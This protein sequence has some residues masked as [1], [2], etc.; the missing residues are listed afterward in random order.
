MNKAKLEYIWIGGNNELRSKTKVMELPLDFDIYNGL[1]KDNINILP[2]WNFDGS[3]TNQAEGND[4][5]VLLKPVNVFKNPFN[6]NR[7]IPG[8]L[9]LCETFIHDTNTPH[10]TNTRYIARKIFTKQNIN[11]YK[12]LFGIEREFFVYD[13]TKNPQCPI[14]WENGTPEAQGPYYCSVGSNVCFGKDFLEDVL[15]LSLDAN[16]SITGSNMEVCPGQMEIQICDQGIEASDQCVILS[17]ILARLG[18]DYGYSIDWRAKPIEGDW[19]GSGCHVNFSTIQ[20]R[21]P[22][23]SSPFETPNGY[24]EILKSIERLREKHHEHIEVYGDDNDSRLTG[25]H[26][27]SSM[28]TFSYGVADRGASIRIPRD[29]DKNGYGY[30]EDRR[31]SS[32]AD[33]YIV[34]SKIFETSIGL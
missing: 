12:P 16:L 30:F 32:S 13:T 6:K 22:L 18:E 3:S 26:E 11:K 21:T 9:V 2:I 4:S 27:T 8:Y 19:N 1:T 31:P 23:E 33:L 14:G 25:K 28:D 10:S 20:M 29:T 17:Y 24:N 5:E 34:T 15:D 7:N